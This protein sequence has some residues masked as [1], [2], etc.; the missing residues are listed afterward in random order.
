MD[1]EK[2]RK[3]MGKYGELTPEA[4]E[5]SL[6]DELKFGPFNTGVKLP[7]SI[8]AGL[9]GAGKSI[10]DFLGTG[11][12]WLG[13]GDQLSAEMNE[14]ARLY[15]P[16][17]ESRPL[18]TMVGEMAPALPLGYGISGALT[19]IP[20]MAGAGLGRFANN[21]ATGATMG[22]GEY[23][24]DASD[25]VTKAAVGAMGGAVGD[26]LGRTIGRAI[27][28]M[29]IAHPQAGREAM[30]AVPGLT[31]TTGQRTGNPL[32]QRI[33]LAASRSP[34]GTG[35]ARE[36][37]LANKMAVNQT[38]NRAM[39]QAGDVVDIA[40]ASGQIG[41]QY[42]TALQGVEV[43]FDSKGVKQFNRINQKAFDTLTT[44]QYDEFVSTAEQALAKL[45]PENSAKGKISGQAYQA[46]K[47]EFND[48]IGKASGQTKRFLVELKALTEK[49]AA[50]SLPKDKMALYK[51]AD[52]EWSSM[53]QL[54]NAVDPAGN[55]R[56]GGLR[57]ADD[58]TLQ[59]VAKYHTTMR[60]LA[61]SGTAQN[62]WYMNLLMNPL[63]T[64]AAGGGFGYVAS[65]GDPS[66]AML[67]A[68]LGAGAQLGTRNLLRGR[69]ADK[70]TKWAESPTR[71][72]IRKRMAQGG[73]LLGG[74]FGPQYDSGEY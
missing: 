43:M 65:G 26:V 35:L 70:L 66:M 56:W 46:L 29:Q 73:G 42:D 40:Q 41:K 10:D 45:D 71:T 39:G 22:A 1:I 62:N 51:K 18:A 50:Q 19:K 54:R 7:K 67:G 8:A 63:A 72:A 59:A 23:S 9:V 15:A 49:Q 32:L 14:K 64:G 5:D 33:E 17:R 4:A 27:Q 3:M 20:G 58:P 28:P 55:V 25:R 34:L 24:D 2:L 38:A 68:G 74:A 30:A 6:P 31:L 57:N 37:D 52:R 13:G 53:E 47:Q 69:G 61:D 44:K 11:R 21:V 12:Q 48:G 16:L 60:P 36:L